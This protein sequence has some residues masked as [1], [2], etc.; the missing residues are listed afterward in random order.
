[1]KN[2]TFRVHGLPVYALHTVA[3]VTPLLYFHSLEKTDLFDFR[4]TSLNLPEFTSKCAQSRVTRGGI[5]DSN[6]IKCV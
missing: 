6:Q 1:M 3:I 4:V 2:V 5:C